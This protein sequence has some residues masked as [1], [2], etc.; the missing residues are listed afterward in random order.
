MNA[1]PAPTVTPAI[2]ETA[3]PLAFRAGRMLAEEFRHGWAE[4]PSL[5]GL[6]RAETFA[7]IDDALRAEYGN[8]PQIPPI[9]P[10]G[11]MVRNT[12]TG[13]TRWTVYPDGKF[14]VEI[15]RRFDWGENS[16]CIGWALYAPGKSGKSGV[17]Y[18]GWSP[19]RADVPF[20]VGQGWI[21]GRLRQG[22][23]TFR[24]TEEPREACERL[25]GLITM[26]RAAHA[27]QE[28]DRAIKEAMA[29]ALRK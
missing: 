15:F 7:R 16:P 20:Q 22:R 24:P 6:N 29:W 27:A 10:T 26:A 25:D 1:S 3:S 14:L 13:G 9:R 2:W 4:L 21:R 28:A 17:A 11:R 12:S 19:V 23:W 5:K 18:P 8:N